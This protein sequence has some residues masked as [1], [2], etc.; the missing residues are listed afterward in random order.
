MLSNLFESEHGSVLPSLKEINPSDKSISG[1]EGVGDRTFGRN[2]LQGQNQILGN[3]DKQSKGMEGKLDT[4]G[5]SN[6]E[7][8]TKRLNSIHESTIGAATGV[9]AVKQKTSAASGAVTT[10]INKKYVE[11]CDSCKNL[12]TES[13]R[14]GSVISLAALRVFNESNGIQKLRK[15]R[16]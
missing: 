11:N 15:P 10:D 2:P 8:F 1:N 5:K 7:M 12:V 3:L 6:T 4:Q 14:I 9:A 13:L 16:K